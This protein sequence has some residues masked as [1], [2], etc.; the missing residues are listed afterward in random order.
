MAQGTLFLP[1]LIT[2]A[3]DVDNAPVAGAKAYFYLAGTTTPVSVYT[4]VGLSIAH[5]VP[6]VADGNGRFA[7]IFLTPGVS[8]KLKLT[9]TAGVELPTSPWDN[10]SAVPVSSANLDLTGTAGENITAGQVVYLSDGSASKTA[11]QWYRADSSTP[12]SSTVP[13]IGIAPSAITSATSGTI[14][15]AGQVTGVSGLSIGATYYVS[16]TGSMT[17]TAPANRR[18]LGVADSTT[19]LVLTPNPSVAPVDVGA[20]EGRLTLTTA[21]AVTTTDVTAATTLYFTPYLGNRLTL[22]DGTN[23]TM[24]AFSEISIAVP[25]STSQMY[26]VFVYD[27]AGTTTLELLAWTNDT[28]RATAL[29]TQDGVLCKTGALTRR[30]LGCMRTTT[31]SAQT[32]DSIAKRYLWNFYNR[33][34]RVLYRTEA[35][36]SWTYT[37]AIWRQANASAANQ[38]DA[39]FGINDQPVDVTVLAFIGNG[40]VGVNV[41][42]SVGLDSTVAPYT[43]AYLGT[44]TQTEA[45][46]VVAIAQALVYPGVGRHVFV[47]LEY[48]EATGTSTWRSASTGI[49]G[50]SGIKAMIWG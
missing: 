32:E 38:L 8:Y 17:S 42:V 37:T 30:Y 36:G 6:V 44:G 35:T 24:R 2:P 10:V 4:N 3:T 21:T 7:E 9:T 45:G 29:T 18:V 13:E 22:F 25:A 33:A 46:V 16:T 12:Y 1:L 34:P 48:S 49:L 11:G 14:R 47:W 28:T 19:S 50:T 40:S 41:A 23:W 20:V 31:V 5:A 26:D 15:I 39:V 27:N 43:S